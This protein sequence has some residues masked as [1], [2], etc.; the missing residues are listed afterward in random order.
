MTP[1]TMFTTKKHF[2]LEKDLAA[3]KGENA[4]KP[5][6]CEKIISSLP[7]HP[8]V[9]LPPKTLASCQNIHNPCFPSSFSSPFS[10]HQLSQETPRERRGRGK[11][12]FFF[13]SFGKTAVARAPS[14]EN[15]QICTAPPSLDI[16]PSKKVTKAATPEF[17]PRGF[18]VF[19][20]FL[21]SPIF[22]PSSSF[23]F[24]EDGFISRFNQ[25]AW[26]RKKGR[27]RSTGFAK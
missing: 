4:K 1:K 5:D 14:I 27:G 9:I 24:C 6:F 2:L 17:F 15:I 18:L 12:A 23:F 19:S 11:G 25:L 8:V 26:R 7:N 22:F 13:L 3:K 16:V 21:P 20:S 10:K